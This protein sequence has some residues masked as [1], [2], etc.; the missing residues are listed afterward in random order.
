M[1]YVCVAETSF[2]SEVV[3]RRRLSAEALQ[4]RQHGCARG[5]NI[6]FNCICPVHDQ[7]FWEIRAEVSSAA[8]RSSARRLPVAP[9]SATPLAHAA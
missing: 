2:Q 7:V 9:P 6:L 8:G 3:S 4:P 1:L 5:L